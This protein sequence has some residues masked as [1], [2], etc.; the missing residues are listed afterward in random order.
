M[1]LILPV[2][3][4]RAGLS[5]VFNSSYGAGQLALAA[6][7][8][9]GVAL[10]LADSR[11]RQPQ[12]RV[13]LIALL[14]LI[15]LLFCVSVGL[16][17]AERMRYAAALL[18]PCLFVIAAGLSALARARSWMII[19]V[20][21]YVIAGISHHSS[22]NSDLYVTY[23]WRRA[24]TQAPLHAISRLALQDES[25]PLV[26][27][28]QQ[29]PHWINVGMPDYGYGRLQERLFAR[30]GIQVEVI[31]ESREAEDDIRAAT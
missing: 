23:G 25:R 7:P 20:V 19:F 11:T 24:I 31:F 1:R 21:L 5:V 18:L 26:I 16:V 4:A 30:H 15:A 9:A 10:A 17:T 6:L 29:T 28:F 12:V 14:G 3:F 27:G 22:G 13:H 8:L 2:E